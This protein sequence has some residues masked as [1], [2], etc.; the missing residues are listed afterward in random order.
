MVKRKRGIT[1]LNKVMLTTI[2]VVFL[3]LSLFLALSANI[4]YR[5]NMN[6]AKDTYAD[7][8]ER[9]AS[10]IRDKIDF[11]TSLLHL[12][13]QSLAEL[14]PDSRD[15]GVTAEKILLAMMNLNPGVYSA[16]FI[17][18][19]DV[20]LKEEHY[21]KGYI[22][23]DGIINEL[24]PEKTIEELRSPEDSPWYYEPL[25]TGI[26]YFDNLGL[27]DYGIGE[28]LIYTATVSVPISVNGNAIGVC[29][30]D[31]LYQEMFDMFDL[32]AK[33][34][35]SFLVLTS[36]DMTI[37]HAPRSDLIYS[38]LADFP[39]E[40]ID[41]IRDNLKRGEG[42][43]GEILSPFSGM[44][45]FA[46]VQPIWIDTGTSRRL[47]YFYSCTPFHLLFADSYN[48]AILLIAASVA[49]LLLV[50]WII[51]MNTNKILR[52]IKALTRYAEQISSGNLDTDNAAGDLPPPP[53]PDDDMN[54]KNEVTILQRAF[55][56]VLDTLHENLR[57]VER[58]VEERTHELNKLKEAAQDAS[59]A[60]SRFLTNMSHEI[61][62]PMNAVL[63]MAELL[64]SEKLNERQLRFVDDIK[65]S[66]MA[67]LEIINDVLDLSKIQA[68]KLGL[69]PV[70]Y[71]FN[72]LID[73]I[74]S[75]TKCLI[76]E[77]NLVF[78]VV[79]K[80][81]APS[82][83]FGDDVRLRQIL[84]NVLGNAVKFTEEGFV[85]LG[86]C[87][88]DTDITFT[89]SDTGIGISPENIP[90]LF[91]AF[92]QADEQK[93][94][95]KKGT[96]LWLSI[97]KA[98]VLMM[99]GRITVE[100][101]YG[102]GSEFKIVIP[103][104]PGDE[105]LVRQAGG[106]V[107]LI[108]APDA[109]ILVVDDDKINLNV[110]A[111][112]LGLC[113]ITAETAE[114]GSRAI[115]LVREKQYD[116][117]FMD[118]MMPEM[119]GAEAVKII[120]GMGINV[121]I[122]AL[123]ANAVTGA[124]ELLLGAGMNDF[125]PKPI[126]KASLVQILKDW[127]PPEK[128][129]GEPRGMIAEGEA[130]L[131]AHEEDFWNEIER[132]EELS[133]KMGLG[134]VSGRRDVYDKSLCLMIK[135]IEKCDRNLNQFLTAGDMR[136]FCVLS[137]GM[138]SALASIG[139]AALSELAREL[140]I[141]SGKPDVHFCVSNLP[142]FLEGLNGLYLK[143]KEA[144]AKKNRP[145]A[146][147]EIPPELPDIFAEMTGAFGEMNFTAIDNAMARLSALDTAGA[148]REEIERIKD[149]VLVMDYDAAIEAM[150][151]TI[152]TDNTHP[153]GA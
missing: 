141:A 153:N 15:A 107:K 29:G 66:A 128:I 12:T 34:P 98:L 135:E 28:G 83:L 58:R 54:E 114:S 22:R 8:A 144:Y 74:G 56:K 69:R 118:H 38:N 89:V 4:L 111:G 132:I 126:L 148:L 109:K 2:T 7:R 85:R 70:H 90:K 150:N 20:Y 124:K 116:I 32:S 134:I 63:G 101:V 110:A 61:R 57:T 113:K 26:A 149:A 49:C 87:V 81:E 53:L 143:L 93:N 42:F 19:P 9:V 100:S 133:V 72:A 104:V 21:I 71:D 37:L 16:W 142:V 45:S 60:K 35:D 30:V 121:P 55:I 43:S 80:G 65:I 130:E 3:V 88:A 103:K 137:H 119:D 123:T 147:I 14:D 96:G 52:P 106:D 145:S 102:K 50:V 73:H 48:I 64:L 11:T 36:T 75:I 13:Q 46:S 27:Y 62:T 99:G 120:R 79:L 31:I 122:I 17:F 136:N 18:E 94:R 115:E 152:Q 91:D 78:E 68:G 47:L 131:L 39:F 6:R 146:R 95:H 41:T 67:L 33:K 92:E 140:E 138:K 84:I 51:F 76:H 40:D 59:E 97:T 105:T 125:L 23:Q 44:R 129:I 82:C 25:S 1:T 127:L 151:K 139:A 77:K 24:P 108:S 10:L 5:T 112:L 86:I 117:V